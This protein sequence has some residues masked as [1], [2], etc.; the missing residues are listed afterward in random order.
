MEIKRDV[1]LASNWFLLRVGDGT[2]TGTSGVDRFSSVVGRMHM[3]LEANF[4]SIKNQDLRLKRFY[5]VSV[6]RWCHPLPK[7]WFGG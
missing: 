5:C 6:E 3:N 7:R 4:L 2:G 1:G